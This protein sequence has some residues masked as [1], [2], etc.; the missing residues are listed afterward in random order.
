MKTWSWILRSFVKPD[1]DLRADDDF[2]TFWP[3]F[4]GQVSL[5][6]VDQKIFCKISQTLGPKRNW[7]RPYNSKWKAQ[8]VWQEMLPG[9]SLLE[10]V[11][12]IYQSWWKL[13]L[14][15][16]LQLELNVWGSSLTKWSLNKIGKFSK[17]DS[18]TE[19][20]SCN[21][22]WDSTIRF[23]VKTV[24]ANFPEF[25]VEMKNSSVTKI[26]REIIFAESRIS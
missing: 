4:P 10:V 9:H 25:S 26:L 8:N 22:V 5:W 16:H 19:Q 11:A 14:H 15:L 2:V 7:W 3:R 6:S 24:S 1:A 23:Y 17:I 13:T 20:I 12:N 18:K 21:F